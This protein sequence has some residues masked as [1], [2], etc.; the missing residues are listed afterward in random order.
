MK[1]KI[2][3]IDFGLFSEHCSRPLLVSVFCLHSWTLF[4]DLNLISPM[5]IVAK[6]RLLCLIN[7]PVISCRLCGEVRSKLRVNEFETTLSLT[8]KDSHSLP[9]R[10]SRLSYKFPKYNP[11]HIFLIMYVRFS[12]TIPSLNVRFHNTNCK[13]ND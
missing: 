12:R 11:Q 9:C 5:G 10:H 2:T 3:I 7:Y 8:P 4:L 13:G 1:H 6:L